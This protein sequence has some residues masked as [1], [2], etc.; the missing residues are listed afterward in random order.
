DIKRMFKNVIYPY[1][2]DSDIFIESNIY[3]HRVLHNY[4]NINDNNRSDD[5]ILDDS[6]KDYDKNI[7]N[8]V[9]ISN[10]NNAIDTDLYLI[11]N[12]SYIKRL[13]EKEYYIFNGKYYFIED[14]IEVEIKNDKFIINK[15]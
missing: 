1:E 5:S 6:N 9:L 7:N 12:N 14:N 15:L 3:N 10:N 11:N 2:N 13:F 4:I 8:N